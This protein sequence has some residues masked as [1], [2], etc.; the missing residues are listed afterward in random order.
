L[1]RIS[2]I[3]DF[4]DGAEFLF[5]PLFLAVNDITLAYRDKGAV[6]EI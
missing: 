4:R 5:C 1:L 6:I 2:R 3:L